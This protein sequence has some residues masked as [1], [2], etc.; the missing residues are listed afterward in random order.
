MCFAR[1]PRVTRTFC[2]INACSSFLI[3]VS[4]RRCSAS[5][6]LLN[7]QTISLHETSSRSRALLQLLMVLLVVVTHGCR[8]RKPT[9]VQSRAEC[10]SSGRGCFSS[11][12]S[13]TR[14]GVEHRD[15][16]E[17]SGGSKFTCQ[18]RVRHVLKNRLMQKIGK[19]KRK[20]TSCRT[21]A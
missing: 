10:I 15:L 18:V 20:K 8:K 12:S 5:S 21:L 3:S 17:H 19:G 2:R 6:E 9:R 4:R 14:A 13:A 16:Q 7:K 1:S 11:A